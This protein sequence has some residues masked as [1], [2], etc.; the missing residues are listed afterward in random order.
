M[1][2]N[3][4]TFKIFLIFHINIIMWIYI[5]NLTSKYKCIVEIFKQLWF[6]QLKLKFLNKKKLLIKGKYIVYHVKSNLESFKTGLSNVQQILVEIL[7]NYYKF[8]TKPQKCHISVMPEWIC[9]K[10]CI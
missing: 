10:F 8:S 1:R 4:H 9:F 3:D 5:Q 6:L 2:P 7:K